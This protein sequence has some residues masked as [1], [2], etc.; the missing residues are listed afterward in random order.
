MAG[1]EGRIG[2]CASLPEY[3]N[4]R[5]GAFFSYDLTFRPS[6]AVSVFQARTVEDKKGVW[7]CMRW[8]QAD[9]RL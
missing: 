2:E 7:T 4:D 5:D 1:R 3:T 9:L 8:T 6:H